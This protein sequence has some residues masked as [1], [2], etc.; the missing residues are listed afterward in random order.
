MAAA[1][2]ASHGS[3]VQRGRGTHE[4]EDAQTSAS[5]PPG[6]SGLEVLVELKHWRHAQML[7]DERRR[8]IRVVRQQQEIQQENSRLKNEVASLVAKAS[9]LSLT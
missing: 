1:V 5:P 4:T 3:F 2:A 7:E 9:G 8:R 6:D